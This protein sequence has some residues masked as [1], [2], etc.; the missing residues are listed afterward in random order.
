MARTESASATYHYRVRWRDAGNN[1]PWVDAANTSGSAVSRYITRDDV[2]QAPVV[3]GFRKPLPYV[4]SGYTAAYP[5]FFYAGKYTN[6][7]K[8]IIEHTGGGNLPGKLDARY[9]TTSLITTADKNRAVVNML[10]AVGD[11]KWSAGEMLAE[12][13]QSIGLIGKSAKLLSDAMYAASLKNW[14][15]VAKTLGVPPKRMKSG[16]SAAD[17]WLQYSFGWTPI[18]SDIANSALFLSGAFDKRDPVIIMAK[19]RLQQ[20][21]AE[22]LSGITSASGGQ[23]YCRFLYEDK[24]VDSDEYKASVYFTLDSSFFRGLAQYGI[25]G[26]STPWA[27]LPMSFVADWV[28][29]I[30]DMLEA[31]DATIGLTYLGGSY[32][33]FQK[34]V[35]TR[36][37]QPAVFDLP[38]SPAEMHGTAYVEPVSRFAMQRSV[39]ETPPFP[40]PLYVKNPFDTFKAV[41]SIALLKQ[42]SSKQ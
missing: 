39:W 42:F 13:Q 17:G 36:K 20:T 33:S 35:T 40:V 41:T 18:V 34:S 37:Y 32:T 4:A 23:A 1:G 38:Y 21:K 22:T 19:T 11:A 12:M 16:T 25:V 10:R 9:Y 15:K 31:I 3:N 26:L 28:I 5:A 24:I 2:R 29:P 27:L 30:G 7:N 14:R 6:S 8:T